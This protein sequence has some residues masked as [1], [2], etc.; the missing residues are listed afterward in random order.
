M[1]ESLRLDRKD[2]GDVLLFESLRVG[3][4]L[5]GGVEVFLGAVS[6]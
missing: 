4:G 6:T 1:L 5:D 2:L 3:D